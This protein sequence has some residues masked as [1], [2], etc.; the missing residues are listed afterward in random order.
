M[1]T[2]GGGSSSFAV[3]LHIKEREW[4]EISTHDVETIIIKKERR[5]KN[6][7]VTEQDLA[8]NNNKKPQN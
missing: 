1:L 3:T 7:H 5:G 4:M 8:K 2:E 6:S